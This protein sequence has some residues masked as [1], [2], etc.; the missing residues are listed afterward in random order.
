M[1]DRIV[2][3]LRSSGVPFRLSSAPSPE[4]LPPVAEPRR[5]GT[6]SVET[7]V[8]IV[9]GVPTLACVPRDGKINLVRLSHELGAEVVEGTT[10]DLEGDFGEIAAPVPPLGGAFG[11]PVVIDERLIAAPAI[12]FEAFSPHD[13]FEM[14]YEQFAILEHPK[15]AAFVT[16]GELPERVTPPS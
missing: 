6:V 2:A 11:A 16:G 14:P 5:P 15:V 8:L 10:A 1:L 7:Q 9:A 12:A 13:F 3:Y 4:P